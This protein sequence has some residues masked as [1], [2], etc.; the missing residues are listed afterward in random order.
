M[1]GRGQVA[2][3]G[4]LDGVQEATLCGLD[5]TVIE[6]SS[7]RPELT[8]AAVS[9]QAA[10]SALQASL[11]GLASPVTVTIDAEQGSLHMTQ[12]PKSILVVSTG[13]DANLGAVRLE[14]RDALRA[15]EE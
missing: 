7:S 9:L 4:R 8:A 3:L 14:M 5:G 6:S 2:A 10:L 1:A 12:T 13:N 15:V 11:P